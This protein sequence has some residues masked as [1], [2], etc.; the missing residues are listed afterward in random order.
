MA[1]CSA[2]KFQHILRVQN[3]NIDG[4][5]NITF[6]MTAIKGI[7]RRFSNIICKKA[8]IDISKVE[9]STNAIYETHLSEPVNLM[10]R[11]SSEWKPL[12]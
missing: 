9:K 12:C 11:K 8:D 5:R 10:T 1:L 7:G 2:D 6:A 4:Q 3:T